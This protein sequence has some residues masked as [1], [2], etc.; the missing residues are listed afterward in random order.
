MVG[1]R[2]RAKEQRADNNSKSVQECLRWSRP[3]ALPNDRRLSTV[4]RLQQGSE[5]ISAKELDPGLGRFVPASSSA[6][7]AR[8]TSAPW[9]PGR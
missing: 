4:R 1:Q 7:G 5:E 8:A 9:R 3:R 6:P 2:R